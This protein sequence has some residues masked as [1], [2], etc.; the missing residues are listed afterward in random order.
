MGVRRASAVSFCIASCLMS[1]CKS[2]VSEPTCLQVRILIDEP[3]TP[4]A[5]HRIAAFGVFCT[6]T[7]NVRIE[8]DPAGPLLDELTILLDHGGDT[9]DHAIDIRLAF[10]KVG[11]GQLESILPAGTEGVS[12]S[13]QSDAASPL[14]G[15]GILPGENRIRVVHRGAPVASAG[16]FCYADRRWVV[17]AASG[18]IVRLPS[19]ADV[20]A[21]RVLL[22]FGDANVSDVTL[23][24][25][26]RRHEFV[27]Q[28]A[29][30][31]NGVI[32]AR[33][34]HQEKAADQL[35]LVENVNR[36]M[37]AFGSAQCESVA[38]PA[39]SSRRSR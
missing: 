3:T 30:W 34:P 25:F 12:R 21:D 4:A 1:G 14:G 9:G 13:G 7:P 11:A 2:L 33:T 39:G 10:G 5:D 28:G 36:E 23:S 35:R 29:W 8:V 32:Q 26:L 16:F 20:I 38:G 24:E 18:S 27:A 15:E 22:H 37:K 19:G 17:N 31:P 6:L